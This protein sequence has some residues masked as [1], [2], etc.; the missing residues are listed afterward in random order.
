MQADVSSG[1]GHP[2]GG[3]RLTVEYIAARALVDSATLEDAIPRILAAICGALNWDHGA[4]WTIDRGIDAMRCVHIW[5]EPSATFPEFDAVSRASTFHRGVGIPGRVWAT[6]APAWVADVVVDANFPRASIAA[7]EGLHGA[8]GFPVLVR[9]EVVYVLEFFSRE[10]RTPDAELLA[11]LST[12]GN[13]IGM[14]IERRRAQEELD[15]FFS[16]SNDMLCVA[17]FDGYFKRVNPAWTRILGYTEAELLEQPYMNLVY[18]PDREATLREAG[19]LSQGATVVYFENRYV[20]KDGTH[21]WLLWASTPFPELQVVYAAARDITERKEAEETLARYARDLQVTHRE[22]EEQAARLAQL[23]KELDVARQRAEAAAE[24]KSLFLANMSHEIRTPLN[25]ILGM[26][27]LALQTRLNSEQREYL[28]TVQSSAES[29]RTIINDIL[30]FS[31]IE[32][33]R[34]DLERVEFDVREVVGDAAKLLALRAVEKQIELACHVAADVPEILL[35]DPGRVKQVILNV[36]GNAVKFTNEGEVVLHVG[37]DGSSEQSVTLHFE[38]RD[39]GI[40]IA[41]DQQQHIFQPFTQADAS[42]TRRFGGTGLG[43]AISRYLVEL[44][45]GRIWVESQVGRGSAFHFTATFDS[46]DHLRARRSLPSRTALDGLR[47]LVVDDNATN[48]RILEEMLASWHMKPTAVPDAS[49]ALD[50][51]RREV[52]GTRPFDAVVTDCQMPGVDGFMLSRQIKRDKR[53]QQT[54]IVMLTS[55]G[56]PGDAAR[57]RKVGID[58]HLIKPVKQSD[59]LDAF[60]TVFGVSTRGTRT[61]RSRAKVRGTT[62]VATLRPSIGSRAA[63]PLRVLVAEDNAVNRKL[64]TTLLQKRGHEVTAVDN[65]RLAV[66]TLDAAAASFDVVLM[67]LQMPEMSGFEAAQAIRDREGAHARRLP[68]IALTAHAMQ[69]DRERCLAAGMD[70]Y[71]PKPI[72]VEDLLETVERCGNERTAGRAAKPSVR[73]TP[74]DVVFDDRVALARTGGDRKL[75]VEMI[76]LFRSDYPSYLRR[77]NRALQRRDGEALRTSAHALKGAL[78]TVASERGRE[79]AAD[80]ERMGAARHFDGADGKYNRLRDHL[81]LLEQAFETARLTPRTTPPPAPRAKRRAPPHKRG[82]R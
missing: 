59:L 46:P 19:K 41:P 67:D 15:R 25:A 70:G 47:V 64:V 53:L 21:R 20:H 60:V 58:A 32:A 54:P 49:A 16:L 65:G 34:L 42:T 36:L 77:I 37:V 56:Q 80:L 9:G 31:K 11:T 24:A 29:L 43:L 17:G 76:A 12:V 68:I 35:G 1:A 44:M 71:L 52:A 3:R 33:R 78:A 13:Q 26:T 6:A 22:L 74:A 23:V 45:K 51:L 14:F 69:G 30:D 27:A 73:S 82:R 4:L 28:T 18:E 66:E 39:T 7:R 79:L 8:F 10:V 61:T 62:A 75:L 57:A 72:D 38:V 48:R 5:N 50:A 55:A 81:A 40:G 2:S 63:R